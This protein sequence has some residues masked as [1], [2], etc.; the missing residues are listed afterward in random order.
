MIFLHKLWYK[1][2]ALTWNEAL[3]LGNGRLGAMAYSGTVS[4]KFMF[5]E[6][7]LWGGYPHDR[8]NPE[9]AQYIP[10][11]KELIQ[12]KKYREADKLVTEKLI[13]TEASAYL[14][15]GTLTVDLKKDSDFSMRYAAGDSSFSESTIKNYRRE[16]D[17]KTAVVSSSFQFNGNTIARRAI[18]SKPDNVF[19][20]EICAE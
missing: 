20:A 18:V 16:L 11:L 9:A 12:N 7:T 3:P 2:E 17:L 4:E 14:P 8:S 6:E 13:G 5:N 19:A 15:F 1:T 10:Q